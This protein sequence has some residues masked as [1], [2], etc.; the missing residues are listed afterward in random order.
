MTVIDTAI[1]NPRPTPPAASPLRGLFA[2]KRFLAAFVML[3]LSAVGLNATVSFLQLHFKKEPVPLRQRFDEAM[4]TVIG[5][6]IQVAR[7]EKLDHDVENALGT[8]SDKYLFCT[9]IN[10]AAFKFK[11]EELLTK[12][13]GQPLVEQQKLAGQLR[14]QN[15]VAVLDVAL[16]YY[17]GK[18]DTVAHIPERCYLGSGFEMVNPKTES[19]G[20][21]RDLN[22][23]HIGFDKQIETG[24]PVDVAYFF[25]VNGRYESDSLAVRAELQNL[26]AKHGYY[27]K[28]ELSCPTNDRE[29]SA[30]SMQ[31]FLKLAL[32]Y[33]EAALPDWS[34][35][36]R[37]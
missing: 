30:K 9:Y 1:E 20:L 25:H 28:V 33:A 35:Y 15:P 11:P 7:Q 23:R 29:A 5:S 27:A 31:E 2:S 21:D 6:W 32:P 8:T 37:K 19:W 18:A 34:Q 22:V 17:T 10:A 16:A 4:P 3:L 24:R 12:F 13:K 26:L 14:S 36:S